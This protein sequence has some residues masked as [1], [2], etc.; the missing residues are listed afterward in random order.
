[1]DWTAADNVE[2][3]VKGLRQEP[4]LS[5]CQ[6]VAVVPNAKGSDDTRGASRLILFSEKEHW[7]IYYKIM[8]ADFLR[9]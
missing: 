5:I 6:V 3:L 8:L 7:R 2:L 4:T 9:Q 1:M